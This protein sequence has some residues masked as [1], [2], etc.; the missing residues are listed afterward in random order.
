MVFPVEISAVGVGGILTSGVGAGSFEL[1]GGDDFLGFPG[2]IEA[3]GGDGAAAVV[4]DSG[5]VAEGVNGEVGGIFPARR[6][7]SQWG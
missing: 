6:N 3:D 4:G 2:G 1:D 7:F 5:G